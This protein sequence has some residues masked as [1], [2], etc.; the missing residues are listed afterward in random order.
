MQFQTNMS[1]MNQ[2]SARSILAQLSGSKKRSPL[3]PGIG[4][5]GKHVEGEV[6]QKF[7]LEQVTPKKQ[8]PAR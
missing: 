1:R 6:F 8:C 7:A 5:A 2:I 3:F 4:T